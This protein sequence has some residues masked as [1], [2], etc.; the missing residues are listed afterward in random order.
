MEQAASGLV[1][2]SNAMHCKEEHSE[3]GTGSEKREQESP[4]QDHEGKTRRQGSQESGLKPITWIRQQPPDR[5][6]GR[7]GKL[8]WIRTVALGWP[9]N[10]QRCARLRAQVAGL[11]HIDFSCKAASSTAPA[12]RPVMKL[13]SGAASSIAKFISAP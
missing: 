6:Q 12:S 4:R 8:D 13:S 7:I 9:R 2:T 10:M 1:Q 11:A 5:S 3:Q